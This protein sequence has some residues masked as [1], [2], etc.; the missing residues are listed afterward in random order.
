MR[1]GY[2]PSGPEVWRVSYGYQLE[3]K[4]HDERRSTD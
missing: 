3:V 1:N 2:L 4:L